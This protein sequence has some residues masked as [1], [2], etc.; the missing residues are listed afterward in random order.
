MC[1]ILT[2][3]FFNGP[4]P[5][6]GHAFFTDPNQCLNVVFFLGNNNDFCIKSANSAVNTGSLS[7]TAAVLGNQSEYIN[8]IKTLHN[9]AIL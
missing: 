8:M 9:F 4:L 3:Q 6:I 1:K 7:S 5:K 2:A